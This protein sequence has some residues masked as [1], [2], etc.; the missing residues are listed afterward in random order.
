MLQVKEDQYSVFWPDTCPHRQTAQPQVIA[1]F[2]SSPL[3]GA[4]PYLALT[5]ACPPT[6]WATVP[7]PMKFHQT[8]ILK[9][10]YNIVLLKI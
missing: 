5:R 4:R 10:R 7:G 3:L 8:H 1:H 9:I 6:H 2:F